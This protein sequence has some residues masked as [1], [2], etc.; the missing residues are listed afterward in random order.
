MVIT[1]LSSF[2]FFFL[3]SL[4]LLP[5]TAL[6]LPS[7][8]GPQHGPPQAFSV[9]C[10]ASGGAATEG[11][12][13]FEAWCWEVKRRLAGCWLA[14]WTGPQATRFPVPGRRHR[15]GLTGEVHGGKWLSD[16]TREQHEVFPQHRTSRKPSPLL[17]LHTVPGRAFCK[18]STWEAAVPSTRKWDTF[19]FL[20]V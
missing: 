12:R 1:T 13:Q 15:E 3:L 2:S 20:S 5:W 9:R 14:V 4:L 7:V 16:A 17:F 11:P 6:V 10:W 8:E 18:G 19:C